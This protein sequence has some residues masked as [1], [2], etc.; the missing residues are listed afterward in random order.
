[1]QVRC[2]VYG[3]ADEIQALKKV[4]KIQRPADARK[5]DPGMPSTHASSLA[6]LSTY[7]AVAWQTEPA[8]LAYSGFALASLLVSRV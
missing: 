8:M 1:M 5:Q 7:L 2:F 3:C 6:Y 4:I